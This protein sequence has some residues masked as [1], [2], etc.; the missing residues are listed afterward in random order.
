MMVIDPETGAV[1]F[2]RPDSVLLEIGEIEWMQW[3]HGPIA[4]AYLQ[5]L[6]DQVAAF[7]TLAVE[8]LEA[9]AFR[10]GDPHEDKNPDVVRGKIIAL[11]DLRRIT[12]REIQGF[13]GKELPEEAEAEQAHE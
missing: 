5:F 4:A 8:L 13:Y 10:L 3:Q 7:R 6:E 2:D 1:H 9:G 12:L 11:R